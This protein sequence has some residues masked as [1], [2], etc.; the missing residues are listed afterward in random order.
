[1]CRQ[2]ELGGGLLQHKKLGKKGWLEE[3]TQTEISAGGKGVRDL[4][5]KERKR[6]DWGQRTRW[7][8][9]HQGDVLFQRT[10]VTASGGEE[11]FIHKRA[12]RTG[13]KF[14]ALGEDHANGINL[15]MSGER[16]PD[17]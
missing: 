3:G 9:A 8:K 15:R 6:K 5:R 12:V 7:A 13:G 16:S 10:C 4:R 1:M 2:K 14:D 17:Q 11:Q